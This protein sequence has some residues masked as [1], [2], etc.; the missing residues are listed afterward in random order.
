MAF[1][2]EHGLSRAACQPS[3]VATG[4]FGALERGFS[5]HTRHPPSARLLVAFLQ[6]PEIF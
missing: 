4:V 5:W 1:L 3:E 2:L 6:Q